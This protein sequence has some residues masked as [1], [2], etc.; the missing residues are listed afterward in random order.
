MIWPVKLKIHPATSGQCLWPLMKSMDWTGWPVLFNL[1][2][3]TTKNR[4]YREKGGYLGSV[5]LYLYCIWESA[6]KNR[7][8]GQPVQVSDTNR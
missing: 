2:K 7:P 5:Y 1:Q 3:F 8:T 4:S 6:R